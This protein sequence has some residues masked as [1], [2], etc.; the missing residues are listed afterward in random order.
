MI[1]AGTSG[2]GTIHDYM[3]YKLE[4]YRYHADLVVYLFSTNDPEDNY[5]EVYRPRMA[6]V[7]QIV[8]G[9]TIISK[10]AAAGDDTGLMRF[11]RSKIDVPPFVKR[12]S[13]IYKL[14]GLLIGGDLIRVAGTGGETDKEPEMYSPNPPATFNTAWKNTRDT[15]AI[16]IKDVHANGSDFLMATIPILPIGKYKPTYGVRFQELG[17]MVQSMGGY[18]LDPAP[19]C[20]NYLAQHHL[21]PDDLFAAPGY[22]LHF[23]VL[24]HQLLANSLQEWIQ[25]HYGST[26]IQAQPQQAARS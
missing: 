15:L 11:L 22:D 14:R 7:F 10:P 25:N 5:A 1:G 16:W 26:T 21:T 4:G 19:Y 18:V 9:D 13:N 23:S 17:N 2:Y 20:T 12:Y 8:P 3:Y 24:A 6:R